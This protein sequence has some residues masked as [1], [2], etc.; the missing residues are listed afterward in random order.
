LRNAF[1]DRGVFDQA[2]LRRNPLSPRCDLCAG[3]I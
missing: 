3:A 1:S 2:L